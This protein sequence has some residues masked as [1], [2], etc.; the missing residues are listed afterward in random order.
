MDLENNSK[1][2]S[3]FHKDLGNLQLLKD[4]IF[5]VDKSKLTIGIRPENF[6][7]NTQIGKKHSKSFNAK[8]VEKSFM[9]DTMLY[10]IKLGEN[11]QH[12]YRISISDIKNSP[13]PHI[14]EE[15]SVFFQ[16]DDM[17]AYFEE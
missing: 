10:G 1:T 17:V 13:S 14:G 3:V 7:I 8:V 9:G 4:N 15:I 5:G 11:T 6:K 16:E 2:I 12:T